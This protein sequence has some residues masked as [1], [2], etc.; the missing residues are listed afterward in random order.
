MKRLL[1]AIAAS[2]V[3][4]FPAF[5]GRGIDVGN[6]GAKVASDQTACHAHLTL[7]A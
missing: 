2:G 7:Y 4:A 1:F 3:I 5:A 6:P